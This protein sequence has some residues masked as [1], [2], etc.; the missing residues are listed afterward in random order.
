MHNNKR[1]DGGGDDGGMG[2]GE[3]RREGRGERGEGIYT[4]LIL[5]LR[6]K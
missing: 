3:G 2:K 6:C 1:D 4:Y 5:E